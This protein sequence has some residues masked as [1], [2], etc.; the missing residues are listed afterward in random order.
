MKLLLASNG[1][2]AINKIK[3]LIKKPANQIKIAWVITASKG[4]VLSDEYLKRH[5]KQMTE[6]GYDFTRLDIESYSPEKLKEILQDKDVL[7]IEG[8]NVFYLLKAVRQTKFDQLIKEF[9]AQGGLYVGSSAGAY[10][11]CPTIEMGAWKHQDR[12]R[13]GL[14]DLNG[15][16]YVPFLLTAHYE[17][18]YETIIREKLSS[19]KYPLRILKDEQGI[20]VEGKDIKFIGEGKEEVIE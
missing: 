17:P 9:I 7:Y 19:L 12:P 15:L 20:L 3:D 1:H 18:A 16:N 8:G 14:E 13:Y 4:G 11:M 6:L 10:I 5:E 2:F